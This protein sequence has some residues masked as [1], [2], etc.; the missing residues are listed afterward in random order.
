MSATTIK[1]ES[2]L[3]AKVKTL[4]AK[5]ESISRFVRGLI[6]KEHQ[7]RENRAAAVQYQQF[8]NENPDE[9][10]A[11]ETWESAPLADDIE[12]KRP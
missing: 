12:G 11:Q 3:V 4:K 10:A 5:E 8:L 1:L 9:Y 7:S 6:E 2:D